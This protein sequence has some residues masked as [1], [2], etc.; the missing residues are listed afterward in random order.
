LICPDELEA[1]WDEELETGGATELERVNWEEL[2][3][4]AVEDAACELD[5]GTIEDNPVS[6]E[7]D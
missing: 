6:E 4:S 7:L 1:I 3:D 2:E 5:T